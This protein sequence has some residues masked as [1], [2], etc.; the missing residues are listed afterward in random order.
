MRDWRQAGKRSA[1]RLPLSHFISVNEAVNI[2]DKKCGKADN[3]GGISDIFHRSHRPEQDQI[4]FFVKNS[5][6][7]QDK[8]CG[9][10]P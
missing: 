10:A 3:D 8:K 7:Q 2:V 5:K 9:C 1:L 4:I 6:G